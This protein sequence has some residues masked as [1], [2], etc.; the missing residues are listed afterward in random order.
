MNI[1]IIGL[2][3]QGQEHYKAAKQLEEKKLLKINALVDI[4]E[5]TLDLVDS[6]HTYKHFSSVWMIPK[7]LLK[8]ID[9]AIIAV[10]NT[11]YKD[12]ISYLAKNKI[13]ILKEKPFALNQEEVDLYTNL[14]DKYRIKI[15]VSQQREY[16]PK[17]LDVKE[18][19]KKHNIKS[20]IYNFTL[21]D[22]KNSWYWSKDFGGGSWLGIG[23]HVCYTIQWLFEDNSFKVDVQHINHNAREW[24]YETDD[25]NIITFTSES[26]ITGLGVTS[27]VSPNKLEHIT[28]FGSDII[29]NLSRRNIEIFNNKNQLIEEKFYNKDHSS[30]EAQLLDLLAKVKNDENI[31]SKVLIKTTNIII[32]NKYYE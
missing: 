9:I 17:Y 2:G 16:D 14:V 20:F 21:N 18:L 3:H 30:Y 19:I 22:T 23:W 28:L 5:N 12:I 7:D 15:K 13:H 29:I 25:T 27:V 1:I 10:P 31:D 6:N 8:Q 11:E 24:E 4:S 26:N 32:N